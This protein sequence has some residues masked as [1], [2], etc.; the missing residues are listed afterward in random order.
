MASFSVSLEQG[1]VVEGQ[2]AAASERPA[3]SARCR[4]VKRRLART[5]R[6]LDPGCVLM[7]ATVPNLEAGVRLLGRATPKMK[8]SVRQGSQRRAHAEGLPQVPST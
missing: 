4:S 1:F 7:T 8:P 3:K 6:Q 2:A 5:A